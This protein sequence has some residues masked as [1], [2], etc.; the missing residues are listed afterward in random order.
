MTMGHTE[1]VI[2]MWHNGEIIMVW[3]TINLKSTKG[4]TSTVWGTITV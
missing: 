3:T 1:V 4:G 2:V